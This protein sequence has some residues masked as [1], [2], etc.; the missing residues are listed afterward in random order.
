MAEAESTY[1]R[2]LS[3]DPSNEALRQGLEQVKK[4]GDSMREMQAVIA[5]AR[6]V[7][8]HPKLGKYAE[9][10]PEYASKLISIIMEIQKDPNN[11]KV[12]MAQPVGIH[13]T[14][15]GEHGSRWT[16]GSGKQRHDPSITQ[17]SFALRLRAGRPH[18]R[19]SDCC[20]GRND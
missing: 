3:I 20:V 11:L 2:G 10:D 19:R 17:G 14:S 8:S 9:E 13:T 5:A 1:T 18:S 12:V 6:A 4:N 15:G 7:R 16:R